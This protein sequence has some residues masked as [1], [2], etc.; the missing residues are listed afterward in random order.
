[1]FYFILINLA[2]VALVV[3]AH[4]QGWINKIVE[5]DSTHLVFVIT[6]M[7]LVGFAMCAKHVIYLSG[8]LRKDKSL[9]IDLLK[10]KYSTK[11]EIIRYIANS[12]VFTGLI[13]TVI[14]FVIALS[15][16]NPDIVGDIDNIGPMVSTLIQGMSV[17]LYTTLVGAIFNLW[18]MA[19]HRLLLNKTVNIVTDHV[20]KTNAK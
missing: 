2:G 1:M 16:V 11:L 19:N 6:A 12:L 14:G 20:G 7:F 9:P 18:L 3:A 8:S 5:G 17:A 13:G 15:G 4:Y 10:I